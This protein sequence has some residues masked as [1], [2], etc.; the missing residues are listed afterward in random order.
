LNQDKMKSDFVNY[1]YIQNY[2]I[3]IKY[4]K[5]NTFSPDGRA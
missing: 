5:S 2:L 4:V 1:N 3:G